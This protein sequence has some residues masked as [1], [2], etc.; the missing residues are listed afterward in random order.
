MSRK[1]PQPITIRDHQADIPEGLDLDAAREQELVDSV[2][3]VI[4]SSK[5]LHGGERATESKTDTS[6]QSA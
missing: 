4:R 2:T 5:Q 1:Q 6:R 3:R